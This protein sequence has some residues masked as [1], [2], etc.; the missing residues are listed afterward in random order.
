MFALKDKISK[1]QSPSEI[2]LNR[3]LNSNAHCKVE[4]GE[5][6][7]THEEHDSTMQSQ[8][9]GAIASRPSNDGGD[10]SIISLSTGL[11]NNCRSWTSM[12][13]PSEVVAQVH[14]LAQQAK[15]KEKLTFTDTH[16]GDIDVLCAAIEHNE[17]D[18]DLA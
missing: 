2:I 11:H 9:I 3:K 4:F 10:Y 13:V 15:A 1:T 18:V 6:V 14:H 12:P 16:N 8:T 17:D 7:Q 5:Y